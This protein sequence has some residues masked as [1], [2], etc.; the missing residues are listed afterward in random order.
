MLVAGLGLLL[1]AGSVA[2]PSAGTGAAGAWL[3]VA[4]AVG[5]VLACGLALPV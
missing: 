1:A 2:L 3:R 5:E 4:A